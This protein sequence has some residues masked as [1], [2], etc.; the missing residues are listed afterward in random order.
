MWCKPSYIRARLT[1]WYTGIFGIMIV[2]YMVAACSLQ[3]WQLTQQL[4]HAEVQDMETVEGLLYFTPAGQLDLHEDYHSRPE[5]K[6]LLDRLMEVRDTQGNVLFRNEKLKGQSLGGSPR[7]HEFTD[8]H[9][10]RRIR[11]EDGRRVLV[12]S[13]MHPL[14]GIPL[15]IRIG[16]STDPLLLRSLEL[17]GLLLLLLPPTLIAA[18]FAGYRVAGKALHPIEA[19]AQTTE[20]ITAKQLSSRIHIENPHDEL[21]HM[22]RVLNGLL[23]RLEQAFD[24]LRRFTSDVSHELRTP[25]SSIRCVGEVGLQE[26][27]GAEEY[28]QIISS[29]LEEVG[30]LT[31]VID[32]LLTIAHADAG[33]SEMN[34]SIFPLLE[35]VEESVSVIDV[36]ADEKKQALQ[37]SGDRSVLVD[38]DRGFLRMAVMNLLDNAIKYSPTGS[39]VYISVEALTGTADGPLA[40]LSI[41]DEGPGI[42]KHESSRIFD[43]FYRVDEGRTRET[44][45]AGLGLAIAKCAVEAHKGEIVLES[46][47]NQGSTFAILLPVAT[48]EY[49]SIVDRSQM[50]PAYADAQ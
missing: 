42:P 14:R 24:R 44:G 17:S 32:T 15:F 45:G 19:M 13:H 16:Y 35:I 25:L 8:G 20:Q 5:S 39:T 26:E 31:S 4:F 9:V 46:S 28:K 47:T 1:L 7:A 48:M 37:I 23:E 41:R 50:R 30:R 27:H 38:A 29:M 49:A 21:G 10:A 12:V 40:K 36:L 33:G 18:G 43:R 6:L 11:L 22:A 3:Y 34:H 2:L